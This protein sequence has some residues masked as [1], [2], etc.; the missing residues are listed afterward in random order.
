MKTMVRAHSG[1]VALIT[2]AIV[3]L[4]QAS[5]MFQLQSQQQ[6]RYSYSIESLMSSNG[7]NYQLAYRQSFGYFDDITDAQWKRAQTIHA[8]LF[9]NH[10]GDLQKYSSSI[11]DKG[12]TPKLRPSQN[13][14]A[15][16]FQEEFHCLNSQ[17]IPTDSNGDGPKWVCDPHRLRKTKDCLVYSVGSNG[18]VMFEKGIQQ[19]IGEHCEIHTFDMVT[20]NKRN[21]DF[22]KALDGIATFH[23]W[24]LGTEEEAARPRSNMKTLTQTMEE[25]GHTG[26]RVDIF[27]IDCEW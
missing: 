12:N 19:E 16:N 23:A 13:W 11:H 4:F 10:W 21:G 14:N 24:G 20:Y 26:R 5:L 8:K 25:L 17:R 2:L 1:V 22:A 9:P 7:N 15:E 3:I 27:K 6:D 18:N